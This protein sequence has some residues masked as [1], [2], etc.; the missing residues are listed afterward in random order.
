LT[1]VLFTLEL[2]HDINMLLPLL[3]AVS[4]AHAFTVL[5]MKRSI[6]T[7]KIARRGYHLTREY[8]ID[9]LEI[10]FVREVMTGNVVALPVVWRFPSPS[11][12]L[13]VNRP[14]S[15]HE[16]L[17]ICSREDE[18]VAAGVRYAACRRH[19]R[20]YDGDHKSECR[21]NQPLRV[22]VDAVSEYRGTTGD[23]ET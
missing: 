4:V 14:H 23:H 22:A 12:A 13:D 17:R 3:V 15:G 8:S 6:L 21:T 7:E 1:G 19:D 18:G 16:G 20:D 10:L 9:P 5:V 2:T 11:H